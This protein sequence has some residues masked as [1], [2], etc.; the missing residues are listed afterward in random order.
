LGFQ[1]RYAKIR[2]LARAGE[3]SKNCMKL[4][5]TTKSSKPKLVFRVSLKNYMSLPLLVLL[6]DLLL[7]II[8]LKYY[9]LVSSIDPM[10]KNKS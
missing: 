4:C 1:N 3:V 8:F 9:Y 2:K 10:V 5:K 7:L 6:Q